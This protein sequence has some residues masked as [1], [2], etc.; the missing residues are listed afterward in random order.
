V[1]QPPDIVTIQALRG[2]LAF[3]IARHVQRSAQSQVSAAKRLGIPQPTL[4][5]IMNGRVVDLSLELLIRIAVRAGMPIVLQTGKDPAEA[6]VSLSGGEMP[7]RVPKSR[8]AD[9]AK[10]A[11]V[12]SA[13]RLT[14]EQRLEA[15]LKHGQLVTELHR[16]GRASPAAKRTA[17]VRRSR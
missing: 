10:A 4:S 7:G 2:D 16:K 8:L 15:H 3:Q 9:E 1:S 6:G 11:L 14:P 17:P 13:Q 5:K 12:P